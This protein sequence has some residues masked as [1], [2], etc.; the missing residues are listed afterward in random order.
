MKNIYPIYFK[1]LVLEGKKKINLRQI[2]FDGPLKQNQVLIKLSYSGICGKQV[3]EYNFKMGKDRSH[4]KSVSKDFGR[5]ISIICITHQTNQ[6][7]LQI[8]K[9]RL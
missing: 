8:A 6:G 9:A 1:G 5:S 3:E 4:P 7:R 2:M